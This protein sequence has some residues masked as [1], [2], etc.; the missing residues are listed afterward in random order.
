MKLFSSM[1]QNKIQRVVSVVVA[2]SVLLTALFVGITPTLFSVKA[3]NE[4]DTYVLK[5]APNS[6]GMPFFGQW[7][8]L[9]LGK[10][11]VYSN[12]YLPDT[13][14]YQYIYKDINDG[15]I[16]DYEVITDDAWW[17]QGL[18]FTVP[19]DAMDDPDTAGNKLIWVGFRGHK[20]AKPLYYY[21]FK[22]YDVENPDVNL[23][24]D[25]DLK[26]NGT[27]LNKN[28]WISPYNTAIKSTLSKATLA[29]A[30]GAN[31][32]KKVSGAGYAIKLEP[33]TT[34]MP[35]FGQRV[36][37][38]AGKTYRYSNCYLPGTE[39]NQEVCY[40]NQTQVPTTIISDGE[41]SRQTLEFTVPA[42]AP[43]DG[44]GKKL[45]FVGFRGFKSA[46]P[47]YYFD[48]NLYDVSNP[49]VN[50]L[51]DA[52]LTGGGTEIKADTWKTPSGNYVSNKYS[53]VALQS[54]GGVDIFRKGIATE[55]MALM[56]APNSTGMPWF[57]QWV[58]L[59]RGKTYTFSNCYLP[60]TDVYHRIYY[61]HTD[62]NYDGSDLEGETV[63]DTLWSRYGTKFTLPADA[64]DNGGGKTLVWVGMRGYKVDKPLYYYNFKLYDVDNPNI[65][66]LQDADLLVND[67]AINKSVWKTPGGEVKSTYSKVTLASIGGEDIFKIEQPEGALA[68]KLEAGTSGMPWFGQWVEV[69]KGETYTF[70]NCYLPG[71]DVYHRICYK[72]ADNN[73]DT[74]DLEGEIVYDIEW[75]RQGT[76]FTVPDNAP[77]EGNGKTLLWV[78]MRGY[79]ADSPL[80]YYDFKLYN[81][82]E[83]NVNL[84]KDGNLEENGWNFNKKIWVSPYGDISKAYSKVELEE[85]G[86]VDIFKNVMSPE[87]MA[88]SLAP[89][90]TGMPFFGQ[91]VK[92]E[93]GKTYVFSTCFLPGT[94]VIQNIYL[95]DKGTEFTD[96]DV[97]Y[98][99]GWSKRN[100]KFTV[101]QNAPAN[102]KGVV[103]AW[104]GIRGYK[105]D[106]YLYFYNF[107]LYDV[108][109]PN[110]NLMRDSTLKENNTQINTTIWKSPYNTAIKETY[111]KVALELLG[112]EDVFKRTG[113]VGPK[114]LYY[115][116]NNRGPNHETFGCF[117]ISIPEELRVAGQNYV[118][119]FDARSVKGVG[120]NNFRCGA[121]VPE[122]A[123]DENNTIAPASIEGYTYSFNLRFTENTEKKLSLMIFVPEGAEGYISNIYMYKADKNFKKISDRD[124]LKNSY[125]DFS[126]FEVGNYVEFYSIMGG[127]IG[128]ETGLLEPVPQYFFD[129]APDV[130]VPVGDKMMSYASVWGAGTIIIKL[131]Y[132]VKKGSI[133]GKNYIVSIDIRPTKGRDPSKFHSTGINGEHVQVYPTK[134]EGYTYTFS[135]SER[136]DFSL[137]LEYPKDCE[138]Y[139]SNLRMYEADMDY[140][141][142]NSVNLATAF[143]KNG[144][145]T[146]TKI[147]PGMKWNNIEF[148]GGFVNTFV[149]TR[150]LEK[151]LKKGI[152]GN[153]GSTGGIWPIPNNFFVAQE[154]LGWA[155]AYV[156]DE[157]AGSGKIVGKITKTSGEAISDCT[158]VIKSMQDTEYVK[159]AV[160]DKNG[161][162]TYNAVPIGGYEV[163]ILLKDGTEVLGNMFAWVEEN[164]DI[165]EMTLTYDGDLNMS[166]TE[167]EFE[168]ITETF[169][170]E[171]GESSEGDYSQE[172]NGETTQNNAS[173]EAPDEESNVLMWILI[174]AGALVIVGAGVF[175]V[176]FMKKRGKKVTK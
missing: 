119:Q 10:T 1:F 163:G 6:T 3:E 40:A 77:T 12:C 76:E 150:A 71:T 136:Y 109:N 61:K 5:V 149:D 120:L 63:Y 68:L 8:S 127:C 36:S 89:E 13:E 160:S 118:L 65:N 123:R 73:Y 47:L 4:S 97:T 55:P 79:K 137:V 169:P 122:L 11:Y 146:D 139:I 106:G 102:E 114:M 48:F 132:T 108:E 28:V 82:D 113:D 121:I 88:L 156:S 135:L 126:Q 144:K 43:D 20:S 129:I 125:A 90:T 98:D 59:E 78:G 101:P 151:E 158:V 29:E 81:V 39:P 80:F 142:V 145:F 2:F 84:L 174:G 26:E 95:D 64:P 27:S 58:S 99:S 30:G 31:T 134:V 16:T 170:E 130:P 157:D 115:T 32:F 111:D 176:L 128:T 171:D 9:K 53:K 133:D 72:K 124:M 112:G 33:N 19:S 57:G 45:I 51:N 165:V 105:Y 91:W 49:S 116:R 74:S 86:G 164:N 140:K 21:D 155:D 167:E 175:V 100:L 35:Y 15:Q 66:L 154:D 24:K 110:V 159:N 87:P 70:S 172:N 148:K 75:S 138:G 143:G 34:G 147:Q 22:L 92:L 96:Y 94:D 141:P 168:D 103:R 93:K 166:I 14:P 62:G 50:L 56:L 152:I 23:L 153:Y 46:T 44:N 107:E 52:N 41:W 42:D 60:G 25:A 69:E 162:F 161:E 173:A 54:I 104:V 131:P 7:V 17:R 117:I 18:K 37:L 83:P 85:I 67:T 38:E